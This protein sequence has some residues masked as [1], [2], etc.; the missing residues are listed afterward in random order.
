MNKVPMPATGYQC[1]GAVMV[2]IPNI[3]YEIVKV[4]RLYCRGE[5][6]TATKES[7]KKTKANMFNAATFK[8]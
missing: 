2:V 1:A 8:P 7:G 5:N 4:E 6:R 3:D